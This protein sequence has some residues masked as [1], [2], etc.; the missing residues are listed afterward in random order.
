MVLAS[1]H[2]WI[3]ILSNIFRNM[4][5]LVSGLCFSQDG[6]RQLQAQVFPVKQPQG[7]GDNFPQSSAQVPDLTLSVLD[8]TTCHP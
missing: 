2:G 3:Q 8:Q 6:P 1:K 4:F 7:K 5:Q